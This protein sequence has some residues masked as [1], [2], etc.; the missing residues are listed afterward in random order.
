[1]TRGEILDQAKKT[2]CNDRQDSYG[3]P[4]NSFPVIAKF[5]ETYLSEILHTDI[6][7]SARNVA[8]MLCLFKLARITTGKFKEDN[9]IDL[10]GYSAIAASL[11]PEITIVEQKV[12][13]LN[14]LSKNLRKYLEDNNLDLNYWLLNNNLNLD[15]ETVTNHCISDT[16]TTNVQE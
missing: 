4:E 6:K 12:Q 14:E 8:D 15:T 1:M 11:E 10:C 13:D 16:N 2:I 9:Y 5:W 7:L 3:E